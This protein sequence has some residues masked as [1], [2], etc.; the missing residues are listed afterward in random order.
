MTIA[1]SEQPELWRVKPEDRKLE[2]ARADAFAGFNAEGPDHVSCAETVVAFAV[3]AM[4]LDPNLVLVAR[5]FGGGVAG[6][7]EACGALTGTGVALGLRDCHLPEE[8]DDLRASTAD[9]V[10][11]L[12][13]DFAS[14]FGSCR[15]REL[16]GCDLSTPE[17]LEVFRA[18]PMQ[19]GRC[20][21]YV[22]WA[23]D[24]LAPLLVAVESRAGD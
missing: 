21:E 16:T 22:G 13:R 19:H 4:G 9:G 18:D 5:Y 20:A 11:A 23:C 1:Q 12:L 17:G 24:R 10:Q 15:C 3:G 2:K 6:M 14:E 7:G 8:E